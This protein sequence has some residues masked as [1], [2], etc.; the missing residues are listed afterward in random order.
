MEVGPFGWGEGQSCT[1]FLGLFYFLELL[2][3]GYVFVLFLLFLGRRQGLNGRGIYGGYSINFGRREG[4]R[5]FFGYASITLVAVMFGCG[6]FIFLLDNNFP[7]L[8]SDIDIF[9]TVVMGNVDLGLLDD[10]IGVE[11]DNIGILFGFED[12]MDFAELFKD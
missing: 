8:F 4:R 6:N 7:E 1:L 2:A 9:L 11:D 5:P 12:V 3:Q 10:G